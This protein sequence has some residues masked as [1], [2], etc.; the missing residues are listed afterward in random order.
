MCVLY[1]YICVCARVYVSV[2]KYIVLILFRW[3][4]HDPDLIIFDGT[5]QNLST[6]PYSMGA[7]HCSVA[8]RHAIQDF[9]D[10]EKSPAGVGI[11]PIDWFKIYINKW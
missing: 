8:V 2:C 5:L 7:P 9:C 1:I 6:S 10:P 11:L 3:L 4:G